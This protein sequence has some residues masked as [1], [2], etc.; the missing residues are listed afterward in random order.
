VHGIFHGVTVDDTSGHSAGLIV[1]F[2]NPN[3]MLNV[4]S[5]TLDAELNIEITSARAAD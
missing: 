2:F 4:L 1:K 5:Y 3:E